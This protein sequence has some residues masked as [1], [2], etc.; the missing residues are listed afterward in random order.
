MAPGPAGDP[1]SWTAGVLA[2][3]VQDLQ[4]AALE[5]LDR[6]DRPGAHAAVDHQLLEARLGRQVEQQL[7][8]GDVALLVDPSLA[9]GLFQIHGS[10]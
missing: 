5:R 1:V 4:G 3:G 6:R 8:Q 7:H 10:P 9:D 2:L